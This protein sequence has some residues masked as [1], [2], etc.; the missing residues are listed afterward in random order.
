MFQSFYYQAYLWHCCSQV[1]E[2]KKRPESVTYNREMAKSA[3][4][5]VSQFLW[6]LSQLKIFQWLGLHKNQPTH[7]GALFASSLLYATDSGRFLFSFTWETQC[8]EGQYTRKSI[9]D[10]CPHQFRGDYFYSDCC[11]CCGPNVFPFCSIQVWSS[12][13]WP[14]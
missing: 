1:N 13:Y 14:L 10:N 11:C 4:Q 5:R 2:N 12:H 7:Q 6:R 3:P 8:T 9:Q